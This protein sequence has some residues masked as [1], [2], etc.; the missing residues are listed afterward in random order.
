[1]GELLF[2]GCVC[3]RGLLLGWGDV[4]GTHMAKSTRLL[5]V[6]HVDPKGSD[7]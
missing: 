1:M 2:M 3:T 4:Q 6:A 5:G 7:G